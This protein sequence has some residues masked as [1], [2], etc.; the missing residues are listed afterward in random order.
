[1]AANI[2]KKQIKEAQ[3]RHKQ[4]LM[5]LQEQFENEV[6]MY[7]EFWDAKIATYDRNCNDIREELTLRHSL[8]K[9][10]YKENLKANLY[11][12]PGITPEVVNAEYQIQKLVKAQRYFEA[13][14]LLKKSE[15]LVK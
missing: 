14:R 10:K 2:Q 13:D 11:V 7:K 6:C 9:E 4:E 15:N 1:M 12:K 3:L 5:V 8:D